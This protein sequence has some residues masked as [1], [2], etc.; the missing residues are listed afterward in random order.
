MKKRY[1]KSL[2]CALAAA[3][4][5]GVLPAGNGMGDGAVTVSAATTFETD[6]TLETS[7]DESVTIRDLSKLDDKIWTYETGDP[8]KQSYIKWEKGSATLPNNKKKTY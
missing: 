3:M 4:L 1:A 7:G 8:K 5:A 2:A 6:E